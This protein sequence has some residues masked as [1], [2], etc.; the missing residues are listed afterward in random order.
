MTIGTNNQDEK[1][2]AMKVMLQKLSNESK[3]KE[4]HIKF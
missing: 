4:A 1:M 2:T 3:E